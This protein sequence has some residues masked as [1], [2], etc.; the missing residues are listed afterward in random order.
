FNMLVEAP[1]SVRD[2]ERLDAEFEKIVGGVNSLEMAA[3][4]VGD[5]FTEQK[6][7]PAPIDEANDVTFP[8]DPRIK[9]Q[10]EAQI[11]ETH[12]DLPLMLTDPVV[13]Y[14]NYFS[15][16]GRAT[17]EN[18]LIRGGRYREVIEKILRDQGVPPES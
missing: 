11:K 16:R 14:I 5:G 12:S 3:L 17:L 8:V 2:D 6:S 1:V 13:G 7:E 9:A 18:S 4:K 10:A 15:S